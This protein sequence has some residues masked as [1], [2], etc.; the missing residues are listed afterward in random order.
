MACS[1]T[2]RRAI[3]ICTMQLNNN[4]PVVCP[5]CGTRKARRGCPAVG[6]QICA[7][8]CGT[9]RLVEIQCPPDCSWL[10]SARDHPPAVTVR[11]QRHDIGLLVNFMR[12]LSERQSQLFFLINSFIT[13][14]QPAELQ[15]LIDDDVAEAVEALAATYE[16]SVRGVIYD[17]RP[18]SLPADRL[19]TALRPVLAEAGKNLGTAFERDAA[20]VLRRVSQAVRDVRSVAE[21]EQGGEADNRKAFVDLLGR[22][23]KHPDPV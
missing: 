21:R 23:I 7:V 11:Q 3:T 15:S 8:C 2:S 20:V 16:T 9:K 19:A 22:V 17:H 14:Y 18:A 1:T 4:E 6:Q 12:D 13:N 5:L 10:A